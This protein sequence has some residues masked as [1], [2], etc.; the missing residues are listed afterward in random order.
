[1]KQFKKALREIIYT[2]DNIFI[3]D[4]ILNAIII[5]LVI[6]FVLSFFNY[7]PLTAIAP[8]I[9]YLIFFVYLK[10]KKDKAKIIENKYDILKEKLRTARDNVKLENPIV[11]ELQKEVMHDM[12]YVRV[13]SFVNTKEISWKVMGGIILCFI[14]MLMAI[15]NVNFTSLSSSIIAER[16]LNR[17]I[18]RAGSDLAVELNISED[19]Y[20]EE[21]VA[22]LG[23]EELT[24]KIKP[25]TYKISVRESGDVEIRQFDETFPSEIFV[26]SA[27]VY[28]ENIPKE[29][30][31]LVKSY[32]EKLR[33]S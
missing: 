8:A 18:L 26:E 7:Y 23:D 14:I 15:L 6:Y 19:I 20:G 3:F 32:F 1:M 5:F 11:D 2:L 17:T 12:K 9:A 31:E 13:S 33:E 16:I 21:S 4:E 27:T 22:K 24:V 25:S 28:E 10:I 29:Q 30:Q